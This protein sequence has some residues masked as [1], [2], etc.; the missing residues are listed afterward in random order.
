M[1]KG[2]KRHYEILDGRAT[3][4]ITIDNSCFVPA[5]VDQIDRRLFQLLFRRFCGSHVCACSGDCLERMEK[6][7][8]QDAFLAPETFIITSTLG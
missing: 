6:W 1:G 2:F 4:E 3:I 7:L 5:M 8:L